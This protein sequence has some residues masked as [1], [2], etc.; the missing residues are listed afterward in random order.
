MSETIRSTAHRW[1]LPVGEGQLVSLGGES[2]ELAQM[3]MLAL[4]GS[5]HLT[6]WSHFQQ[7]VSCGY[8]RL[9]PGDHLAPT[10]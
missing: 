8:L 9:L 2:G 5:A 7:D 3:G 1:G 6:N 4:G 10:A